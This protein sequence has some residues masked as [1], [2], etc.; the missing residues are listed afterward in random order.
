[1]GLLLDLALLVG[2]AIPIVALAHR[3]KAPPV[4]GFLAVGILVGPHGLS[5][6]R[7]AEEV[8]ALSELGVA[9]LLFSVGLELSL[10][11]VREW[12]RTVLLGGGLQ[13]VSTIAVVGALAAGIGLPWPQAVFYGALAAMSSTAVVMKN[14][15]ERGE[16]D[17]A[18]GRS[19]ISVLLFQDL[20][21]LPLI[22]LAPVLAQLGDADL[23]AVGTDFAEGLAI[24]AALLIGGRFVVKSLLDRIVI[25]RDRELFTL[26]IAF[27]GIAAALLT[28]AAGFS[29][30]IGAFIAGLIISESEYGL[31]AMSD[32]MPFRSV[33]SGIFFISVG[34][35][36]DLGAVRE[37]AGLVAAVLAAVL[38]LK[39]VLVAGAL[40][41][42]GETAMTAVI[43][44]LS[45]AQVGEFSIIL[46]AAGLP[47]GLFGDSDYQVF[48]SVAVLSVMATPFLIHAAPP[49]ARRLLSPRQRPRPERAEFVS[50]PPADHTLVVG[51]G[52]SGRYLARM[53]HAAGIHCVVVENDPHRVRQA[54]KDGLAAIFGDGSEPAVLEHAGVGRA[55]IIVFAFASQNDVRRGV[56]V[57]R[58]LNP[59]T[60]IIA[61]VR[62]ARGVEELI[63]LGAEEVVVEEFEASIELFAKALE[64]YRIPVH[65]IWEETEA[66]RTE[67]YGLLRG[68][69]SPDLRLDTAKHLGIHDALELAEIRDRAQVIG[70][71]ATSI[72][73]RRRTGVV[74][75]AVVRDGQPIYRPDPAYRYEAGDTV[76]L[77]G[78][79]ES[80]DRALELFRK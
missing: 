61:R 14:Y 65:R 32:V 57:A 31:Q 16:L 23:G 49:V 72:E 22:L 2:I 25:L 56:A 24:M 18:P 4:V 1:M 5:L 45:L 26:C 62:Q 59:G 58:D 28:E 77:V 44:G 52:V 79:R 11:H 68:T 67:H 6:I 8:E 66:V 17:T 37:Q 19:V 60:R 64:I 55:R 12:A 41:L 71:S 78:D 29:I 27:F 15:A 46:A 21:V 75:I 54:R 48:L 3:I 76:V 33:F 38:I 51:Y 70:E 13:V 20:C 39:A 40:R 53:L 7:A 69:S 30:A 47:L 80:L 50:R 73:L 42:A 36:L 10:S 35:L 63:S 43:G 34:M 9:L 74:Q